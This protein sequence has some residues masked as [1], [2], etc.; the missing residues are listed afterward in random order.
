MIKNTAYISIILF[1]ALLLPGIINRIKSLAA[2]R[3][4]PNILQ[5]T[6]DIIKLFS[7][8]SIYSSTTTWI[9]RY[10]PVIVFSLIFT[11]M[12]LLPFG[13][14][15]SFFSFTGDIILFAYLLGLA[16]FVM[17]ISALDTGSSFE[18]MG[19]SREA[20][21]GM[22]AEPAFFILIGTLCLF[23]GHLSFSDMFHVFHRWDY[24]TLGIALLAACILFL[25]ALIENSRLPVDNPKTHLELTMIHEV[26]ILDNSGFDLGLILYSSSLKC[27]LY[28]T[29]IANLFMGGVAWPLSIG[30]FFLVQG[31]FAIMIG[32]VESFMARFRMKHNPQFILTVISIAF[33]MFLG[34]ILFVGLS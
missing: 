22:L 23:T 13:G 2:G 14:D 26:M 29:L 11:A 15:A 21:Y 17:I 25:L 12:L 27:V 28:A 6:Y 20:H 5:Y 32:L 1:S 8:D 30:I 7:K 33:L 3:K 10:A 16:R 24:V 31:I 19:A 4:G 9:F 18:G 34:V